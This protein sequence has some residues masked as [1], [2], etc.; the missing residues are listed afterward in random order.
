MPIYLGGTLKEKFLTAINSGTKFY[1]IKDITLNDFLV[2]VQKQFP[3]L[4]KQEIKKL[5]MHG[6][7]RMHSAIKFGCAI[8]LVSK[9]IDPYYAYIGK[10]TLTPE[11]NI[12][13]YSVRRDRKLR[14]IEG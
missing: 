9:K 8:S 7:R 11:K 6:F 3:D 1:T 2:P 4:T 5:L 10:L 12:K 14:K 13:E